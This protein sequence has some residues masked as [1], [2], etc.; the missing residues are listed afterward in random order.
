MANENAFPIQITSR[1]EDVNDNFRTYMQERL[2]KLGKYYPN[3]LDAR[4]IVD[5]QNNALYRVDISL[6][7]PGTFINAKENDYE[8]PKAFEAALEK[9]KSQLKKLRDRM[10]DHKAIPY[11]GQTETSES[12]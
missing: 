12:Q 2:S 9:V 7:V 6:Q 8:Y 4:V 10:V 3:I 11:S 1:H 5:K